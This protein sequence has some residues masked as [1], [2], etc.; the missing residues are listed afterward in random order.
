L[1]NVNLQEFIIEFMDAFAEGF[2]D[3][4]AEGEKVTGVD[5]KDIKPIN[6]LLKMMA[7]KSAIKAGDPLSSEEI[8]ALLTEAKEIK[9][10]ITCPHGRPAIHK[11]TISQ[12]EGYF[13]R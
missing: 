6:N 4:G 12:L 9:H 3:A 5:N 10:W 7:C 11:I 2:P 1:N 13:N 8:K